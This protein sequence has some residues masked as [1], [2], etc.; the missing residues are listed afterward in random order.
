MLNTLF[1][2]PEEGIDRSHEIEVVDS[3]V[4]MGQG[5]VLFKEAALD[6]RHI[7]KTPTDKLRASYC[8]KV[9]K[10]LYEQH[11]FKGLA[12]EEVTVS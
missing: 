2:I 9:F 11:A 12:F 7:F 6:G 10:A 5:N 3:G 1:V 4:H 8:T